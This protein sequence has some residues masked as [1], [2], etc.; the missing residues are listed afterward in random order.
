MV[1]DTVDILDAK[2]VNIGIDFEVV[3]SEEINKFEVL[4]SCIQAL[5]RKYSSSMFIDVE[6]KNGVII[7]TNVD[8]E[9]TSNLGLRLMKS[10]Y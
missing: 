7:L 6:N 1:N 3:S 9:Y 5:R 10:L 8:T 4:D 2:V